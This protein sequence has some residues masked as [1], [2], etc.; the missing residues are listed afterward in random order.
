MTDDKIVKDTARNPERESLGPGRGGIRAAA[1]RAARKVAKKVVTKD[2]PE[3]GREEDDGR[4]RQDGQE[5][6][7]VGGQ[8]RQARSGQGLRARVQDHIGQEFGLQD[9]GRGRQGRG[10]GVHDSAG[11]GGRG[12]FEK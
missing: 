10:E 9:Q 7:Q 8:G 2:E 4:R 1:K 6:G 11:I 3:E 5:G 12:R